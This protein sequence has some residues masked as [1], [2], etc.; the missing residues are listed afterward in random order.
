M[1]SINEVPLNLPGRVY[2][3]PMPFSS[4][5]PEGDLFRQYLQKG[6]SVVVLLVE[7]SDCVTKTGRLLRRFYEARGLQVIH[8]PIPDFH[9]PDREALRRT[10][11]QAI[12]KARCGENLVVHCHAGLG[13]TGMFLACMAKETLAIPGSEAIAWVRQWVSPRAVETAEQE[14]M[15]IEF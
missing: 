11:L 3:S 9:I 14:R 13:R 5:D 1:T 12:E 7:D 6:I 10:V 15:V 8:L 4:F 2:R